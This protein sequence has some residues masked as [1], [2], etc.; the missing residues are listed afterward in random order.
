MNKP[1]KTTLKPQMLIKKTMDK[2]KNFVHKALQNLKSFLFGGSQ[3]LLRSHPLN[4]LFGCNN[5]SKMQEL[6]NFYR[7]FSAQWEADPDEAMK[8]NKMTRVEDASSGSFKNNAEL[9]VVKKTQ[10]RGK[11]EKTGGYHE[12]QRREPCSPSAN[13]GGHVL[14]QKMKELEKMDVDDVDHALDIEEVLHYYSRLTS[15]IYLDIVDNFF[16][17]MHSEF[18]LPQPSASVNNSMRSLGPVKI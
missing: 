9:S 10:E 6:N 7:E 13:G 3:K 2:T 5:S 12:E 14:A 16:E 8:R 15:P 17:D 4:P 18:F 1:Y 11:E